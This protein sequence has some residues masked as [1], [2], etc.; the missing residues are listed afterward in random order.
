MLK[1][2]FRPWGNFTWVLEN[3]ADRKWDLLGCLSTEQRCLAALQ[4]LKAKNLA[5]NVKLLQ[6]NDPPSYFSKVAD[7]MIKERTAE[8]RSQGGQLGHI[9]PHELFEKHVNIVDSVKD[10]VQHS[11]GDVVVDLSSLPKRFFF[12]ILK[13]LLKI[14]RI[15]SL[16]ATYTVPQTYSQDALAEDPEDWVHIPL[17]GPQDDAAVEVAIVGVGFLPFGLPELLKNECDDIIVKLFFP[18]PPGPPTYQRTWDFVRRIELYYPIK[19]PTEQILRVSAYDAS[20][21]F[22]HVLSI[23]GG[24]PKRKKALFAPYGP[25]PLSLGMCLYAIE[26][27]SVV[28][29]TQPKVYNPEYCIGIRMHNKI[30]ETYAYCVRLGGIDYYNI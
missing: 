29:Y 25:K 4:V 17:F 5:S 9:E 18:F 22:D 13:L 28:Y 14:E 15:N 7:N 2:S 8:Y 26:T 27:N 11:D 12:P 1:N 23:T 19:N 30:P 3:I 24:S 20:D 21:T 10:F 16:I 6:I